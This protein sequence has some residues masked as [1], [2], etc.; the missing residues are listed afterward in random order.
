MTFKLG[1]LVTAI[2]VGTVVAI[3][4]QSAPAPVRVLF[5]GNSL[6]YWN[7]G[8]W[9]HIERLAQREKPPRSVT[10]GRSVIPGAYFKSLWERPGAREAIQSRSYDIVL[11]QEDLPETNVQDFR[12][13]ARRLVA[14]VRQS[15][16][17]PVLLM[18]WD[19]PRLGWITMDGI[20]REHLAAARELNVDVAP[21][22]LAWRQSRVQRPALNLYAPDGEHPNIAG[23]YITAAV[24]YMTILGKDPSS[25]DYAPTGLTA[26]DA[27]FLRK[28]AAETVS[29]FRA[30]Q[31][32]GQ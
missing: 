31:S 19:Y 9:T 10:T 23:T 11:L 12:E 22:G 6:T 15:G 4:G 28:V 2:C 14:E 7:D 17:K 3:A 26:A 5:V 1:I 13:Y 18:A 29:D 25:L 30:T 24:V 8:L 32:R 27:A 16:A 20:A 21:A